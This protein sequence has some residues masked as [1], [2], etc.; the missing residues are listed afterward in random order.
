[1]T[2][3]RLVNISRHFGGTYCIFHGLNIKALYCYGISN[4]LPKYTGDKIEKN[5]LGGGAYSAYGGEER[6]IQG[7]GGENVRKRDHWETQG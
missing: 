5:E 1:M 3:Y 7:I 2:S 6:R 4:C